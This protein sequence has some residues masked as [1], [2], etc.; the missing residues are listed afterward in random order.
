MLND[1][2]ALRYFGQCLETLETSLEDCRSYKELCGHVKRQVADFANYLTV[3]T[4]GAQNQPE[5]ALLESYLS[6]LFFENVHERVV[7]KEEEELQIERSQNRI[8]QKQQTLERFEL[9]QVLDLLEL[10]ETVRE[11]IERQGIQILDKAC[12][13]LRKVQLY[14]SPQRK[15]VG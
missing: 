12:L 3:Y 8:Y 10:S 11:V 15:L 14:F 5:Q 1:Q 2:D 6:E 7:L 9:G 13:E 4:F